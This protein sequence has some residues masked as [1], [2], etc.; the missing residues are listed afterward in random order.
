MF[1]LSNVIPVN[2]L[3][4]VVMTI[5]IRLVLKPSKHKPDQQR[6]QVITLQACWSQAPFKQPPP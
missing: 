6:Q 5:A 2:E 3:R 4:K 1:A